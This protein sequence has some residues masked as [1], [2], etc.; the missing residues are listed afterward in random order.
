MVQ[1]ISAMNK[2][3]YFS[4]NQSSDVSNFIVSDQKVA[5]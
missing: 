1:K 5:P 4:Y 3:S 2:K